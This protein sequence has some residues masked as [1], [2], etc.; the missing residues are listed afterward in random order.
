MQGLL[1]CGG[2]DYCNK[3]I[4]RELWQG[5]AFKLVIYSW[6]FESTFCQQLCSLLSDSLASV[7][8]GC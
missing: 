5:S 7:A 4:P 6:F 8:L 2:I 3:V 1:L